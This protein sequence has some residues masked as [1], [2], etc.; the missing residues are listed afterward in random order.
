[1]IIFIVGKILVPLLRISSNSFNSFNSL[2]YILK[3]LFT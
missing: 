3:F 2:L 1:M